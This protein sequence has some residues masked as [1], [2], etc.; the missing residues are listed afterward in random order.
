MSGAI[1]PRRILVHDYAGHPFQV[2]LSRELAVRG[3]TVLHVHSASVQT[4]Q[5][6]LARCV[7]ETDR[8]GVQAIT[9][10]A[11]I[12]KAAYFR[13]YW[14][15][16]RYGAHLARVV[17]DFRPAVVISANTPL[18]AQARALRAARHADARF[19]F[20]LQDIQSVGFER[21]LQTRLGL[22]GALAARRFG[23]LER[24]LLRASDRVVAISEDF[25]ATLAGFGV[26]PQSTSVIENWASMEEL[27]LRARDN[28]WARKHGIVD[29]FCFLYSGTLGLKHDPE[30]LVALADRYRAIHDVAVVVVS[31]GASADYLARRKAEL[32]LSNLR[33]LPFQSYVV[34]PDVMAS[35]DVLVALLEPAAGVF[36]VPSKVLSYLCAGR[37]LLLAVPADNLAAR[38]VRRSA[39]GAVTDPDDRDAFLRAAECLRAN[40]DIRAAMA[41]NAIK[42]AMQT[43]DI[44]AV[45]DRFEALLESMDSRSGE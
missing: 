33:V 22:A 15:E 24:R 23:G 11:T 37:A 25:L 40:P 35:A 12:E 41:T 18:E 10:S 20:W 8:F 36:S 31:E 21:T 27:P 3:H 4:P 38:I 39:S 28:P 44:G 17:R 29:K 43:F 32:C 5:G 30:L 26:S 1:R 13:R 45:G 7:D 2:Q 6:A 42:Y 34:L 14:Q 19:V 16:R 9:L